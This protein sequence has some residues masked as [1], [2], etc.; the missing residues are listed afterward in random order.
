M[1]GRLVR[2]KWLFCRDIERRCRD[3]LAHGRTHGDRGAGRVRGGAHED[4][5][6]EAR[7]ASTT[8]AKNAGSAGSGI[9]V[10][11]AVPA[12][13]AAAISSISSKARPA[14]SASSETTCAAVRAAAPAAEVT[15]GSTRKR[16]CR[17]YGRWDAAAAA[18]AETRTIA[19]A[20]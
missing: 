8:G 9:G 4:R 1:P 10:A 7:A 12:A 2:C 13:A 5:P 14:A 17:D 18:A 15:A 11:C 20:R 19:G 3:H 6:A 16:R